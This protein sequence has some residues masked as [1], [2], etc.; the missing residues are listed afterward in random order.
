MAE[1]RCPDRI[2][3]L[4]QNSK[5]DREPQDRGGE[6]DFGEIDRHNSSSPVPKTGAGGPYPITLDGSPKFGVCTQSMTKRAGVHVGCVRGMTDAG[7]FPYGD[8]AT[9]RV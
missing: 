1:S 2:R 3:G 8:M 6:D 5:S 9:I 4:L 7:P